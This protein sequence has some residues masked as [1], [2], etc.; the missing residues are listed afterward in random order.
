MQYCHL[1]SFLCFLDALQFY[2]CKAHFSNLFYVRTTLTLNK[3]QTKD[4]EP[5]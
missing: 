4:I 3:I 1:I 2:P 5:L